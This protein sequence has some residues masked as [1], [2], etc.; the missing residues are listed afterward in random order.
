MTATEETWTKNIHI[1]G[2]PSLRTFDILLWLP[3]WTSLLRTTNRIMR[4]GHR[5]R[6]Q[7]ADLVITKDPKKTM[8]GPAAKIRANSRACDSLQLTLPTNS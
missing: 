2:F 6:K 5:L 7:F 1:A 3:G 8:F 4:Y